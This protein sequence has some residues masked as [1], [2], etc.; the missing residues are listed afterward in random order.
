M[1]PEKNS[2]HA[3]AVRLGADAQSRRPAR[4]ERKLPWIVGVQLLA[5]AALAAL[6]GFFAPRLAVRLLPF[7]RFHV[8]QA[9]E[10]MQSSHAAPAA[11]TVQPEAPAPSTAAN[12][13]TTAP[14]ID[15]EALAHLPDPDS[16]L[17][18]S[19]AAMAEEARNVARYMVECFPSDP[20][21]VEVIAR[22]EKWLGNTAAA[23]GHW[24][25][26][27]E[28]NP[29]YAYAHFG[30]AT[31]L[32]EKGD[33]QKAADLFR[34]ALERNPDWPKAELELARAWINAGSAEKSIPV[35]EKHVQRR[36]FLSEAYVLLGQAYL[37]RD[38]FE[39]AKSAYET[40][41]RILPDHTEAYYGLANAFARLGQRERA[42][43]TME[44]F[45]KRK[46]A[47]LQVRK[48]QKSEYDDLEAMRI[49]SSTIYLDAGQVYYAR[50]R[51]AEA[52][53]LWRRAAALNDGYVECRQALA[54]LYRSTNRLP[55]A[56]EM[57]E[58][59]AAIEPKQRAYLEEVVR[60]H[61]D[62]GAPERAEAAR[63]R[64]ERL[65][66]AD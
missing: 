8:D 16:P 37:Q 46:A 49:D 13:S 56:I 31:V 55:Q 7:D 25:R 35:L 41:V 6:L 45:Q 29:D 39:K 66:E 47:D 59:L 12:G 5:V 23:V 38:E 28:L 30:K 60:L 65:K 51:L 10:P 40:A 64:L 1:P 21:A 63:R 33:Y 53:R 3:P 62:L 4:L 26:C 54:W 58:Q 14:K 15:P 24:D 44:Q 50:K 36:P 19:Q 32:A 52:E 17:P 57:L 61:N 18:G 34:E 20:D 27:L 9:S 43:E 48:T 2:R 42:K 22:C 11:A